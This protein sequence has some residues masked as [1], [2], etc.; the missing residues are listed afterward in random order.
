MP[1]LPRM[2]LDHDRARA[3]SK[4][5]AGCTV[6]PVGEPRQDLGPDKKDVFMSPA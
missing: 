4:E 1:A 3:V 2:P 6:L 5:D